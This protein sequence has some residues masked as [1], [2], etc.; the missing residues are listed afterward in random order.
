[1]FKNYVKSA[2]RN[3]LR[4]KTYSLIILTGLSL[5][6][7]CCA[8]LFLFVRNELSYDRFH[9]K[10]ERVYRATRRWLAEDK[11]Q[12]FAKTP[13]GLGP[14]LQS[15]FPQVE[16][17]TRFFRRQVRMSWE[18]RR[19]LENVAFSDPEIFEIF[20]FP[21]ISGDGS[22]ALRDPRALLISQRAAE[23]YFSETDPV[24][25]TITLFEDTDYTIVGVFRD[26]PGNSHLR[27]DFL[28]SFLPYHQAHADEWGISNYFTYVLLYENVSPEELESAMPEFVE[29]Y[30]GAESRYTTRQNFDFQPLTRIH[31]GTRLPGD[32]D[33]GIRVSTLLLFGS[34]AFFILLL[35]CFNSINLSL[36]RYTNR[37]G[38]VA[39]RKI[40]GARPTD[41]VVQF[42]G[43]SSSLSLTAVPLGLLLIELLLPVFN[44]LSGETLSLNQGD[45]FPL[46]VFL[47]GAVL[48]TVLAAGAYPAV[49]VSGFHPG[50][51]LRGNF[52][53]RL[54]IS[55]LRK[56]L[57]ILQFSA[58]ALFIISFFVIA[59]QI[60]FL[61]K[62][63]LGFNQDQ[64]VMIPIDDQRILGKFDT[65]K[66]EFL[67]QS[68]VLSVTGT[69]FMPGEK[70][71]FQNYWKEGAAD[72]FYGMI[73]WISGDRDFMKT[74]Q[75][76]LVEGREFHRNTTA[77]AG[78]YILN[79][80]AVR[81]LGW[82]SPL[83]KRIRIVEEGP[84]IGVM[85]DFHF[86]SLHHEI[87]PLA[88]FPY[89]DEYNYFAVRLHPERITAS[90]D[91]L[92]SVWS[93]LVTEP[94]FSYRFW[95]ESYQGL[96]ES[97]VHLGKIAG[98]ITALSLIIAGLGLFGLASFEVERRTKEIGIR[99]VLG[100]S[101]SGILW[102]LS[103]EFAK[104]VLLA[105]VAAWP[106]AY[107]LM[108]QWLRHFAY[109]RDP[110]IL[111]FLGAAGVVLAFAL[112]SIGFRALRAASVDP[113]RALKYE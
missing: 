59:E 71:G 90:L 19:L 38:E 67:K 105:N 103:R 78:A 88:W 80:S 2:Y 11:E 23:K 72:D 26:I 63:T 89:S 17:M 87:Q 75:I 28:G 22:G 104:W 20:S 25:R 3:L 5:G 56:F 60:H 49:F 70:V 62:R 61:R 100:S 43:E 57:V 94:A 35:A 73:H 101:R 77:D 42:L 15:D 48:F 99:K 4:T 93:R 13:A 84:V 55:F 45:V 69:N 1:M 32:I 14:A 68:G 10:A 65:L 7:A 110:D 111:T 107:L 21:M 109:R 92:K 108:N 66:A 52:Y 12:R 96:Y 83:G 64:I 58:A 82:K 81:E 41:L 86:A 37:A 8:V 91:G 33:P 85:K 44:R 54:N 34:A 51:V 47:S 24:G 9:E 16:R 18:G 39:V 6:L 27:F 30:R 97:E 31:L 95:D 53:R 40:L 50:G 112:F 76:K 98:F 106:A 29:K 74:F 36:A 102:L 79:Q 46:A 113:V